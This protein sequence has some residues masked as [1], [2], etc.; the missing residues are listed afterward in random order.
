MRL[1]GL[2]GKEVMVH[3]AVPGLDAGGSVAR[4]PD[5]VVH[6]VTAILVPHMWVQG[7]VDGDIVVYV[8]VEAFAQLESTLEHQ[9]VIDLVM[10]GAV[11]EVNVPAVVTAPTAVADDAFFRIELGELW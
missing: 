4:H 11:I 5:V 3:L 8:T 7:V 10:G 2:P 6:A 9:V 1:V